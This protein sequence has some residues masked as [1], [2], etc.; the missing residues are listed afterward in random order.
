MVA[1]SLKKRQQHDQ[2]LTIGA[3]DALPEVFMRSD[4]VFG[5]LR[6]LALSGLDVLSPL[7]REFVRYAAGLAALGGSRLER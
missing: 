7:K 4:P 2:W 1:E 5:L 6:D 3:S